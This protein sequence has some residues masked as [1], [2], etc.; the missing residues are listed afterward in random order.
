MELVDSANRLYKVD[1]DS[2]RNYKYIIFNNNAGIQ[3]RD[4]NLPDKTS[5]YTL[6][7]NGKWEQ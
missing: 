5:I 7:D 3:T 1:I 2:S 6:E 4:L